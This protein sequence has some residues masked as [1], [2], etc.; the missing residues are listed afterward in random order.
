MKIAISGGSG[1]VGQ[2]LTDHFTSK[3]HDVYIL[4]RSPDGKPEKERVTYIKW[5]S[6]DHQLDEL[7]F[8]DAVVNL[9]GESINGRWTEEKK[10]KILSSRIQATRSTLDLIKQQGM[11][12]DVLINASAVGYYGTSKTDKFDEWSEEP[13]N[14]FL[15]EVT[16]QWENEALKAND[17]GLRVV[18]TRFG[19]ILDKDEGALPRM[20][21]PYKLYGGGPIGSGE[22]WYSWIHIRDIVGIIDFAIKNPQIEG[23]LNATSPHPVQM[24]DFGRLLGRSLNRPHW[25]PL[26]GFVL[27]TT[28]GEMSSLILEGQK[29]YPQKALDHEYK[30]NYPTLSSA[31]NAIYEQ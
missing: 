18:C 31:L 6:D 27:R 25:F 23:A 16:R 13:G 2:A 7:P 19:L 9:A 5:L 12:P 29:V 30:F 11:K 10:E 28:L 17:Y 4:T 26:P 21:L 3:G 24:D 1:F 20:A 8:L 15:A 22:Q 14:G